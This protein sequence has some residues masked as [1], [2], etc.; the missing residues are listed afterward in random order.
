VRTPRAAL[1]CVVLAALAAV[2]SATAAAD[3]PP[4]PAFPA[5]GAFVIGDGSAVANQPVTFWGAQWWKDNS[6][7]MGAAPPS[8]KGFADSPAS[9]SPDQCPDQFTTLPGNSSDPPAGPLPS[10]MYAY[11]TDSVTKSGRTISGDVVG[12]AVIDTDPGYQADPGHPGTGTVESV[13][14]CA[15]LNLG[16]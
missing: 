13:T 10:R 3:D 15:D 9:P 7:S 14:M 5:T 8:F 1:L 16:L 4:A 6:V 11:V 2:L 12:I